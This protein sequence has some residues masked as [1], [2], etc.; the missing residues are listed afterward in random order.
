MILKGI[1]RLVRSYP[2]VPGVDFTGVVEASEHPE[3]SPGDEMVLTGWRLGEIHWGAY[4]QKARVKGDWLVKRPSGFTLPHTMAIG[5]AGFT[6]MRRSSL[7]R[8]S[9]FSPENGEVLV[10]GAAGGV[11]SVAVAI[12]AKLGYRVAAST[13][14]AEYRT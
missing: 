14:R 4:S 2:H 6:A 7:W 10:T 9:G 5:T 13:D 11:G 3:F 8:R 12:L 1:G